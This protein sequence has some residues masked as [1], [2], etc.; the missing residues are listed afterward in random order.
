MARKNPDGMLPTTQKL[1]LQ[2]QNVDPDDINKIALRRGKVRELVRMGYEPNQIVEILKKSIKVG[3]NQKKI[4][5]SVNKQIIQRDIDYLKQEDLSQDVDFDE[6]RT[7]IL[8]KFRFLYNRAIYEYTNATGATRNSFMNTALAV[9]GKIVEIEGIKSAERLNV[10]LGAEA[11]IT[12]FATE[13][14][15]LDKDDKIAIISTIR[16][17]L[18]KRQSEGTGSVRVLS[19]PSKIPAQ[20]SDNEGVSRKS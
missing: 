8:D 1:N 10:N 17:V 12:K 5:L 9:L 7:E 3:K 4:I 6:K 19:E 2:A 18:R 16:K 20:T 15:K 11:R 14:H 13:V